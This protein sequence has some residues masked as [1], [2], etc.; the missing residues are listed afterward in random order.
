MFLV[1]AWVIL[2][3]PWQEDSGTEGGEQN[4]SISLGDTPDA[5]ILL[6]RISELVEPPI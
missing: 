5:V 4:Q 2:T 3:S 1:R 6:A